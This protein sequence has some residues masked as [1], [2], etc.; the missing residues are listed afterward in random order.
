MNKMIAKVLY[1]LL[2]LQ[3]AVVSA[4]ANGPGNLDLT[5]AGTGYVR[6]AELPLYTARDVV[7]QA[8][9]KILIVAHDSLSSRMY[10]ARFNPDGT[11][12]ASFGNGGLLYPGDLFGRP[13]MSASLLLLQPDGKILIQGVIR[14][15]SD[16]TPDT[17]FDGDGLVEVRYGNYPGG[18]LQ[19][20]LGPDGKITVQGLFVDPRFGAQYEGTARFN[21]DGSPDT[22]FGINGSII[23]FSPGQDFSILPDGKM[24][25][26][27]GS[28]RVIRRNTDGSLDTSFNG[29]GTSQT[30]SI[31]EHSSGRVILPLPDGKVLAA[32]KVNNGDNDDF[33]VARYN[34][35]GSLDTTFNGTGFV[36]TPILASNDRPSGISLQADGKIVICGTAQRLFNTLDIAL[37]RYNLDGSLDTTYGNDGKSVTDIGFTVNNL[38]L[39]LDGSDRA[40]VA[41][42]SQTPFV[43][44]FTSEATAPAD[45]AG[46]IMSTNG[47]PISG[48]TVVLT[49]ARQQSRSA[50]SNAF[51][52]YGFSGISSNE[53]YTVSVSNKRYRFQP[54][55]R[56]LTLLTSLTDVDFVGDPGFTGKTGD[57]Q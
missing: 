33:G 6:G 32:G 18:V 31:S 38:A 44:R 10:V 40:M 42:L 54:P 43:A 24:I 11:F 30:P 16:G 39:A 45:I 12:D 53:V 46:R 8:D 9:G 17:T 28:M 36:I 49:D 48:A 5:F 41:G 52:Y 19:A 15:N 7:V 23:L 14:L 34:S 35:N 13:T 26:G 4:Y 2:I 57:R 1:T 3:I 22:S 50:L 27:D 20:A 47:M 55:S 51:G 29:T 25:A 56:Q 37:V 21:S